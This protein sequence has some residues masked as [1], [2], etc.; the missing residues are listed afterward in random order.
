MGLKKFKPITPGLRTKTVSDFADIT[1]A[2]PYKPL[3]AGKK[4]VSGRNSSGQISVR[5][6]GGGHKKK[7]RI[8]D[9]KRDKDGIPG[10]ISTIEY[11]PNRSARIALV[12]Y[13]DGEKR[14]IIAPNGI[15]VGDQVET[16]K[17]IK[18]SIGNTLFLDDIPDGT[19]IHNIELKPGKGGQLVRAAGGSAQ[20][21]GKESGYAS[22]RM[23]SK[24][25]RRIPVTCKATIGQIGNIDHENVVLGKAGRSRWKGN[26]PKVRGVVMNPVD[27]P[28]GGGEGRTSGGRHPVSPTGVPTKG[29]KTRK[30][31]KY[32]N[33]DIIRKRK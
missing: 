16:G 12:T 23:P 7:Y 9:Y 8:I 15:K 31:R 6:K 22:V 32:S 17:N 2:T 10:K 13:N 14:Y 30:L 20:L 5:R 27:H 4:S 18:A 25:V 19:A 24:E 26:R 11:D 3:I 33:D 21:L 28:H 1:T 29:Y